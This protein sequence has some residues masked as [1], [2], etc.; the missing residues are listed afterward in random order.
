MRSGLTGSMELCGVDRAIMVRITG[1]GGSKILHK[2]SE[3][4]KT[5]DAAEI[6]FAPL[7]EISLINICNVPA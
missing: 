4:Q 2:E 6:S 7:V 3:A 1:S 5:K